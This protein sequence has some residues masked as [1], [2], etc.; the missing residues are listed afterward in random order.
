M[1]KKKLC[2]LEVTTKFYQTSRSLVLFLSERNTRTV[3][4]ITAKDITVVTKV[5][6]RGTELF[7]SC[8]CLYDLLSHRP[9]Y[10]RKI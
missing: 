5:T 6:L 9:W 1:D 8:H 7:Q 3:L 10:A 4:C 2:T